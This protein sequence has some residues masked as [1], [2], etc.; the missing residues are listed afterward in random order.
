MTRIVSIAALVLSSALAFTLV[1]PTAE[2]AC[3]VSGH[4]ICIKTHSD[5]R[6]TCDLGVN[7][8]SYPATVYAVYDPTGSTLCGYDYCVEGTEGGAGAAFSCPVDAGS[9]VK[10]VIIGTDHAAG[11]E[12]DLY[13]TDYDLDAHTTAPFEGLVLAGEGN[14]QIYGS[15]STNSDYQDNLNGAEDDDDIYGQAGDD[16]IHGGSG[17]DE[18]DGGD[19]NDT[20]IG[21]ADDDTIDGGAG[22]DTIT[23]NDGVDTLRGQSDVDIILGGPD[24][25]YI[26]GGSGSGDDLSG[27]GG[28][29]Y[30]CGDGSYNTMDGGLGDDVLFGNHLTDVKDGAVGSDTCDFFGANT[31]CETIMSAMATR[32]GAC[33][34]P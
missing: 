1:T 30:L 23:G 4:D 18:I 8:D 12:I 11:D 5:T 26:S 16:E 27:G 3:A 13:L 29:D 32:P 31:S 15:R 34:A 7:G 14:D 9:L 22:D 25:D 33:P 24:I 28:N 6:W 17:D 10:V 2:A 21:D 19:G 20:L